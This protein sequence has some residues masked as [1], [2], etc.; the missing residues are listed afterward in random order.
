MAIVLVV[1]DQAAGRE[2][3]RATL[4]RAVPGATAVHT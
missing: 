1:N 2:I 4:G 3:A